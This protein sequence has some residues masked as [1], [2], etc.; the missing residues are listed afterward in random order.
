MTLEPIGVVRSPFRERRQAPRQ[1]RAAP[2]A[3]GTI[4][5]LPSMKDAALDLDA[6]THLWVIY[7]F[8]RNEGW[9]PRVLPPRSTR[10][11]G[12][13][14]TR[15]PRRPNPIGLSVVRL[16]RVEGLILY[17]RELD[18]LDGTPVYDLKPYV[19]WSDAIPDAGHGWLED[20]EAAL[21]GR[22]EDP[23]RQ[24]RVT[25]AAEARAQLTWLAEQG[26]AE[27]EGAL[28]A[29]LALGPHPHAYRR[30]KPDGDAMRI[31]IKA[32]RA[33]FRH[34]D[35]NIEVLSIHSGFRRRERPPLHEA[36]VDRFA[37]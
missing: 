36:F 29:A 21:A 6:W 5:L 20:E 14:A 18:M 37:P 31:A 27:L 23:K 4:E 8:D 35:Q 28:R 22:P 34:D 1:P 10:K 15:A 26:Q 13:L 32:W 11:R 2:E 7:G 33:R 25:F 17:V 16:E 24:W 12:V 3:V 9:R 19:A 30:I